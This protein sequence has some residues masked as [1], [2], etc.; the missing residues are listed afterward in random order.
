MTLT[1]SFRIYN[2]FFDHLSHH[3]IFP[4][5]PRNRGFVVIVVVATSA[6]MNIIIIVLAI[7]I[8]ILINFS[9]L[10]AIFLES[11]IAKGLACYF[12]VVTDINLSFAS[13]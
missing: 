3:E 7:F 6:S 12:P 9:D 1:F 11:R 10:P 5:P 8:I 13:L 2:F 4:P